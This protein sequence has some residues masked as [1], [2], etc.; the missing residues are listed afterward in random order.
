[1][2]EFKKNTL[3]IFWTLTNNQYY[4]EEYPSN[5]LRY[6]IPDPDYYGPSPRRSHTQPHDPAGYYPPS[7]DPVD[8]Q[9]CMH[10][11]EE[12][13]LFYID[14]DVLE[15][16][17]DWQKAGKPGKGDRTLNNEFKS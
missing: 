9:C 12:N 1:M 8:I 11:E 14:I 13:V 4:S 6:P 7:P 2:K 17:P 5:Q 10:V 3:N 16:R 15:K